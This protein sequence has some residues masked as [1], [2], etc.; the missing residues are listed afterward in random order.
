MSVIIR[1]EN[2]PWEARSTDIRRF[3]QGLQIPDGG[4][5]I[6][7]GERGDAFIAFN[8][9]DDARQAMQK[10]GGLIYQQ[11]V[12][13]FLSSKMEMHNVIAAARGKPPAA[14]NPAPNSNISA[15]LKRPDPSSQ[16]FAHDID[17]NQQSQQQVQQQAQQ[18]TQQQ[19][20]S[21]SQTSTDP[22]SSFLDV[23]TKI[24]QQQQK[25]NP[26]T[27]GVTAAAAAVPNILSQAQNPGGT[28][29]AAS[30]A[31]S[32]LAPANLVLQ[33]L[34]SNM[35]NLPPNLIAQ[36]QSQLGGQAQPNQ[37]LQQLTALQ[38]AAAQQSAGSSPMQTNPSH[39]PMYNPSQ[40]TPTLP[41]TISQTS[42]HDAAAA[43]AAAAAANPAA[44]P[45][46][47]PPPLNP[48]LSSLP[49]NALTTLL[50]V[51]QQPP[52][53]AFPGVTNPL[54]ANFPLPP[55]MQPTAG[56][57][58]MPFN[59]PQQTQPQRPLLTNP[60]MSDDGQMRSRSQHDYNQFQQNT[61]RLTQQQQQQRTKLC[62][63]YLRVKNLSRKY[64]YR[65]VKLLFAD[66]K[67]RLED[68]K[69][70]ND[71]NGE[72]TGES[73]VQFRSIE[74]A[75]EALSQFNNVFYGGANVQIVPATEYEFVSAL[76]SFVPASVKK[77]QPEG[78][79]CVK[80]TGLPKNWYKRDIRR[81][82]TASEIVSERGIY[83]DNDNDSSNQGGTAYIE[84]VR[85]VDLEKALFFHDEHF[86]S[87]RLEIQPIPKKEMES[88]IGALRSKDNRRRDYYEGESRS[89]VR[90]RS[91]SRSRSPKERDNRRYQ[92]RDEMNG[93]NNG[94]GP[95]GS[96]PRRPR[97]NE[98]LPPT[99][100]CLRLRNIP[101]ATRDND[102]KSFFTGITIA[103]DG[104]LFKYDKTG[105]PAGECYVHFETS[106]DCRKAFEKNRS[107]FGG[108]ILELRPLSLWEFQAA[109]N[110]ESDEV[111]ATF[112][113]NGGMGRRDQFGGGGGGQMHHGGFMGEKRKFAHDLRDDSG[114]NDD[115]SP[116]DRS[117]NFD[118]R[119][120]E[121]MS[122]RGS[123][124][125][126]K[127]PSNMMGG[128]SMDDPNGRKMMR[129]N[130]NT[131]L[132]QKQL[133]QLPPGYDQYRGQVLLMSNV[134]FRA[135]RDEILQFLHSYH[136]IEDTL[137]IHRDS[138]GRPTGHAVVA[139]TNPE[140]VP[141]ALK[142]LN[143][144]FFLL[145][146]ITVCVV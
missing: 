104:I 125:G 38:A 20:P 145:R 48:F 56:Q 120:N 65:D 52:Q 27:A 14:A 33:L 55:W 118:R 3:F 57:I 10:D 85:E 47:I 92:P 61:N 111:G 89:R 69:M 21:A 140:D 146:K 86:G 77:R 91:R 68:I 49:P 75:E 24:Q 29:T 63:P 45:Q 62:E 127:S 28:A 97:F 64:S 30:G 53:L 35:A 124:D 121:S 94:G 95:G 114:N 139:L 129:G 54:P 2:L 50:G 4:V 36:V 58:A 138:S 136:P 83:L 110:Q 113:A 11:P 126:D 102:V 41:H 101:Y 112:S 99:I 88:D 81:L 122:P 103:P 135:T 17:E 60:H 80:V 71:Q 16:T 59:V 6:V 23:V 37:I 106:N 32:G 1:L 130:N 133:T 105:R 25:V 82:F 76:D 144:A 19:Q 39:S 15:Q 128:G 70:I 44:F 108:R 26:T 115:K 93:D 12:K 84:F 131:S 117:G 46:G 66:Y 137:K 141:K 34:Q 132:L 67:L 107:Q 98:D 142:E 7:G 9:D 90:S 13:L 119:K 43:A 143:N 134:H 123:G 72:R 96:Y 5:H 51:Q 100:T 74:D 18:Q 87:S 73:V 8:S 22:M 42:F 78:G 116:S 109:T 79:Y 31:P 40:T